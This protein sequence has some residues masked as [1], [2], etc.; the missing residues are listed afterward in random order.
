LARIDF[1]WVALRLVLVY[2]PGVKGNMARLLRLA[3]SALPLPLGGLAARRSLLCLDN[4][5]E[6][7]DRV[8][9]EPR[10]LCCPLIVADRE[11]LSVPEMIAAMRRGLGRRPGLIRV[12]PALL[13]ILFSVARREDIYERLSR[14]LT[15]DISALERLNWMPQI[16]TQ[17]G[18]ASLARSFA[19]QD[20]SAF[21]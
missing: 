12:A 13:E 7:I 11:T 8:L 5:I 10:P 18:L 9:K 16:S 3:S 14:S 15:V 17:D 6:A 21:D 19:Y 4:L 1:D 2:G 20:R